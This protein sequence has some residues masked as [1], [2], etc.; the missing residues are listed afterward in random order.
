MSYIYDVIGGVVQPYVFDIGS[1]QSNLFNQITNGSFTIARVFSLATLS[2]YLS[3]NFTNDLILVISTNNTLI[4]Y[5]PNSGE[6]I[7]KNLLAYYT[8]PSFTT[9]PAFELPELRYNMFK[10]ILHTFEGV[11]DVREIKMSRLILDS[12][13]FMKADSNIGIVTD[14]IYKENGIYFDEAQS[15]A[16]ILVPSNN[17]ITTAMIPQNY[18]INSNY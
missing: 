14:V 18:A 2:E 8:D 3:L 7:Y 6:Y 17:P 11:A 13:M 15:V 10:Q 1:F 9:V 5:N 16:D 12:N 4:Y